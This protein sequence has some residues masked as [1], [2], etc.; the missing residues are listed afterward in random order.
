MRTTVKYMLVGLF[1]LLLTAAFS[2]P[3]SAQE[4][5]QETKT[6]VYQKYLDNY[7]GTIDQ[8]KTAI[9]AAKEY[10][11]ICGQSEPDK[12]LVAYLKDAIPALEKNIKD[13]E[14]AAAK[15]AA[16]KAERDRLA[17]FD[18]AYRAENWDEVFAAGDAYLKE[19]AVKLQIHLDMRILLASAGSVLAEDKKIN[20]YNDLTLRYAQ[21]AISRINAGEESGSKKWGAY[22]YTWNTKDNALGQLHYAIAFIK[23]WAQDKKD[24]GIAYY[25]K[26][27]QYNSDT[28]TYPPLY[29][30]IGSWYQAKAAKLGEERAAIDITETAEEEQQ[31]NI[32]KALEILSREKAYAERAMD[33]YARAYNLASK[34]GASP[35]FKNGLYSTLKSLFA[36]RYS[37]PED[38][39]KSSD[40]NINSYV[41]SVTSSSLPNPATEPQPVVEKK[42]GEGDETATDSSTEGATGSTEGQRSRTVGT[43]AKKTGN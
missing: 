19:P 16:E 38:E 24:E 36:F 13:M 42:P 21:D 10:I 3:V 43:T 8:K 41:A 7:A 26:A 9:E 30:T 6:A 22:N 27:A 37:G 15:E 40:A 4:C 35:E 29:A 39:G 33:A 34:K 17:R 23:Y 2:A 20:K 1:A 28:K 11:K 5:D 14:A 18:K 12:D 25:Y 32:D 31:A